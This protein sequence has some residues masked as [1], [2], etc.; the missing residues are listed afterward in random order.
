MKGVERSLEPFNILH[1]YNSHSYMVGLHVH[2]NALLSVL[3]INAHKL[4]QYGHVGL[5]YQTTQFVGYTYCVNGVARQTPIGPMF[6]TFF[7]K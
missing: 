4:P 6:I 5:M 1:K 2:N 7:L 3:I